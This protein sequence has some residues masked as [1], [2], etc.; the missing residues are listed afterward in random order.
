[1][2]WHCST[3]F[4]F[5]S[6]STFKMKVHMKP[7]PA[8]ASNCCCVCWAFLSAPHH[9]T[10]SSGE[11][12]GSRGRWDGLSKAFITQPEWRVYQLHLHWQAAEL[13]GTFDKDSYHPVLF[14][15]LGLIPG[16][17]QLPLHISCCSWTHQVRTLQDFFPH[18]HHP[19]TISTSGD[20][21]N[22]K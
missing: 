3:A 13:I 11:L 18:P 12:T 1:M 17:C 6:F 15:Q 7:L 5:T 20:N 2:L 8:L 4:L 16:I 21:L 10:D 19:N 14:W 22:P 9:N